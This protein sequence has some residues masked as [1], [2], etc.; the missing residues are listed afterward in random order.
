MERRPQFSP[1]VVKAGGP[2]HPRFKKIATGKKQL[3]PQ[4]PPPTRHPFNCSISTGMLFAKTANPGN[5]HQ[6]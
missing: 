1:S 2:P 5:P 3:I 6:S 4:G